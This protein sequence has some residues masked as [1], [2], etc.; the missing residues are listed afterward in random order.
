VDEY[1]ATVN[2][3]YTNTPEISDIS[4]SATLTGK[5][6]ALD[7]YFKEASAHSERELFW[8]GDGMQIWLQILFHAYRQRRVD[9]LVLDEPDVFLHPDLQ[10][11]LIH[12]L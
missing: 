5:G 12:I 4:I 7:V 10:R 1:E 2:F 6:M 8:A 3:I 9:T 11:R